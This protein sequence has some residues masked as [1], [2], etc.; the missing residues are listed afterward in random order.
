[1]GI[2]RS[3]WAALV[4]ALSTD[5]VARLAAAGLPP[6]TQEIDG[7]PGAIR[8]GPQYVAEQSSPPR[9]VMIPKSFDFLNERDVV[10]TYQKGKS[11]DNTQ[12]PRAI[13]MQW[14][15]FEVQCWGCNFTDQVTPAPDPALDYDAAQIL[16][17]IVWQAAQ[18]IAAGVWR[19]QKGTVN[20]DPTLIRVGY[21]ITFD[22]ALYTPIPDT[23]LS[24]APPT[25]KPVLTTEI[26]INGQ[27][28][29]PP[30]G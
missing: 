29:A 22:L 24:Y 14:K 8:M 15:E 11:I 19:T 18:G 4:Q 23:T 12:T 21:V 6:L 3:T 30:S 2:Y 5:V 1:M 17:E 27:L 9:I 7:S 26:I 25:V 16:A 28:P 10:Q 20:T 13:A